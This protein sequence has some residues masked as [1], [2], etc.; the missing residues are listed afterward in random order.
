MKR[1]NRDGPAL[2]GRLPSPERIS[3]RRLPDLLAAGA[4]IVDTRPTAAF[5]AGHIP[6]TINIP[7]NRNLATYAGSLLPYDRDFYLIVEG[8]PPAVDAVVRT[9]LSI[10]LDRVAGYLGLEVIG[11]WA[12]GGRSWAASGR[13]RPGAGPKRTGDADRGCPRG[14]GVADRPHSQRAAGAAAGVA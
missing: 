1:I 6:G 7:F 8:G 11:I 10:G 12:G 14:G 3:E 13:S 4:V 5:A 2:L 9:L